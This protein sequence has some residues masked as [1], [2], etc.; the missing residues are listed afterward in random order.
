MN[1]FFTEKNDLAAERHNWADLKA[2]ITEI[3]TKYY[4]GLNVSISANNDG[5]TLSKSDS[6]IISDDKR[7]VLVT[8]NL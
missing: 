1:Q 4:P 2:T 5:I 3:K 8:S 7:Y 6:I